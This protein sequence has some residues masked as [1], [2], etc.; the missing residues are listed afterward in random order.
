MTPFLIVEHVAQMGALQENAIAL[1]VKF[2]NIP[3]VALGDRV[4]LD[5]SP[6]GFGTSRALRLC[7]GA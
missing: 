1:T 7:R 5:S 2:E 4:E 6:A 3:R